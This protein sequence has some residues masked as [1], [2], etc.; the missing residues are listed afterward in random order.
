[1]V[2]LDGWSRRR[3]AIVLRRRVKGTLAASETDEHGQQK[4]SFVEVGADADVYGYSVVVTSLDEELSVFGQLYRDRGVTGANSRAS[5]VGFMRV[6][7]G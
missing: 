4:L 7:D 2:R 6:L 1:V 3:R 5:D